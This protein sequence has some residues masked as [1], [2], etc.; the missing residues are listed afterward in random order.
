MR[1]SFEWGKGTVC[2]YLNLPSEASKVTGDVEVT[3]EFDYK[4]LGMADSEV[5]RD[6]LEDETFEREAAAAGVVENLK[7]D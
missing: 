6:G 2:I 5:E 4:W 1:G 7:R 3:T